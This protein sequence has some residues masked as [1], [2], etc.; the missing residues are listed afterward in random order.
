MR[1]RSAAGSCTRAPR[2]PRLRAAPQGG[3]V[4]TRA[5]AQSARRRSGIASSAGNRDCPPGRRWYTTKEPC[6]EARDRLP[7]SSSIS[8]SDVIDPGRDPRR[9][10]IAP[11]A[12]EDAV[13]GRVSPAWKARAESLRGTPVRRRGRSRQEAWRRRAR[14]IPSTRS[15]AP[16]L[17]SAGTH[18]PQGAFAA[19]GGPGTVTAGDDELY[20]CR[21]RAADRRR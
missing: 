3:C 19:P 7:R 21:R 13:N 5:A 15:D 10:P 20:R 8:A 2:A 18:E 11:R 9:G 4:R 17:R 14:T 12:H 16:C 6:G 1:G